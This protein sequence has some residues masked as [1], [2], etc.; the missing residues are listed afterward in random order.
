MKILEDEIYKEAKV[1]KEFSDDQSER[2]IAMHQDPDYPAFP[3]LDLYGDSTQ[4]LWYELVQRNMEVK[5][6]IVERNYKN[7]MDW[8]AG[9]K[10]KFQGIKV[11]H[12]IVQE[13]V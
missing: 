9:G 3:R 5:Y 4:I 2:Y 8:V 13:K 7:F 1:W 6:G 10:K 12:K 11:E